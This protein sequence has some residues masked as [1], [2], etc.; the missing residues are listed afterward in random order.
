M[1]PSSSHAPGTWCWEKKNVGLRGNLSQASHF[2]GECPC[3]MSPPPCALLCLMC[4]PLNSM[5]P[6]DVG[7]LYWIVSLRRIRLW[8]KKCQSCGYQVTQ[9]DWG[10]ARRP[11]A[12]TVVSLLGRCCRCSIWDPQPWGEKWGVSRHWNV[13]VDGWDF[14]WLFFWG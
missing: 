4:L 8:G 6:G 10:D 2:L 3:L 13:C 5:L 7:H 14:S 11:V 12:V 1:V 9:G